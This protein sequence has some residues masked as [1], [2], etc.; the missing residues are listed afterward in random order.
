MLTYDV[1]NHVGLDAGSY[2]RGWWPYASTA[3][4]MIQH[5]DASG[6]DRAVVFPFGVP[7]AFS[8]EALV[9][10]G[11]AL[12]LIPGRVPFDREN[13]LLA[14]EL[15]RIDTEGRLLMLAMFDPNR[16]VPEQMK[17]IGRAHV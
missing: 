14:Q 13:R 12:E 2:Q 1:H 4:D 6:I 11:K 16:C 5:L 15:D 17:K 3:Q 9:A 7:S 8:T 10:P